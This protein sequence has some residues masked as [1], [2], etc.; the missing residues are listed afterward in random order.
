MFSISFVTVGQPI[1]TKYIELNTGFATGIV[2]FFPGA[3]FLY[4][5]TNYYS[6]GMVL[7]YEA[8]VALPSIIT[9]KIGAGFMVNT[10]E[11]TFGIRPFPSTY[12]VQTRLNRPNK[13][14]DIIISIESG[15][16]YRSLLSQSAIL[17]IGWRWDNKKYRDLRHK[18]K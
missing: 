15:L 14:S 10:N 11:L 4:G 2:P 3:S 18:G 9:G 5:A 8:G 1:K 17:T 13:K 6:N 12:Y 7:D 16:Y